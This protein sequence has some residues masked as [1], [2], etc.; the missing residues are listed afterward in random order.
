MGEPNA[1]PGDAERI[2]PAQ[3]ML[4]LARFIGR[5][6]VQRLALCLVAVSAA[7]RPAIKKNWGPAK[8]DAVPGDAARGSAGWCCASC[9]ERTPAMTN[10]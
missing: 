10:W 3:L 9:C 5:Y 4:V 6:S 2:R 7:G 8:L 1:P